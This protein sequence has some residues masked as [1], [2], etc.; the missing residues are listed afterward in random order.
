MNNNNSIFA[1]IR[2]AVASGNPVNVIIFINVCVFLLLLTVQIVDVFFIGGEV[3]GQL[4]VPVLEQVL[5][6]ADWRNL[7]THPW[8]LFTHMFAHEQIF[9]ILFNMLF[10]YWFGSIVRQYSNER[11]IWPLYIYGGLTSAFLIIIFYNVFPGL[12]SQVPFVQ[13]LGASGAVNAIVLASATLVPNL[14]IRMLFFGDVKLK[15][16]ATF[17]V[18][19]NYASLATKAP[20]TGI[21]HLGGALMGFIYIRQLR[22]GHD[23]SGVYFIVTDFFTGLYEKIFK[24][25]RPRMVYKRN[26]GEE[27]GSKS[28]MDRKRQDRINVILD[29]ISKSG[30]DSLSAEEKAFLFRVSKEEDQ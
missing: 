7:I 3:K 30:Y 2:A 5:L 9:H 11:H 21:G 19:L 16:I 8:T 12:Q 17:I 15:W 24:G 13:A 27:K 20:A 4:Y 6:R 1:D 28:E 18:L 10:L 14:S 22:V 26:K 25:R 23:L 29:K